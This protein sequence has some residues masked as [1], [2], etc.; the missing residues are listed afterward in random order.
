MAEEAKRPL[1]VVAETW[2]TGDRVI[3]RRVKAATLL[4]RGAPWA[5][6]QEALDQAGV[7]RRRVVRVN[8]STGRA[9]VIG[10]PMTRSTEEWKHLAKLHAEQR[11]PARA[12]SSIVPADDEAEALCIGA[13]AMYAGPVGVALKR[14]G[15]RY[16]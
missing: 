5:A 2:P 7:P 3:D 6:W 12:R 13:W 10:G 9:K 15:K 14:A 16:P 11:F 1:T 8:T 4:G